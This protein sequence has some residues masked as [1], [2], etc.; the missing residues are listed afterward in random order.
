MKLKYKGQ[1]KAVWKELVISECNVG[2]FDV[3]DD[4][5][6]IKVWHTVSGI[7]VTL[8]YKSLSELLED[9]ED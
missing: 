9:W 8:Q 2:I 4:T 3:D 5:I 6:V 7:P 1:D